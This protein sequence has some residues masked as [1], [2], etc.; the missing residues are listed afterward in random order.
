[1]HLIK[2]ARRDGNG[3]GM[4]TEQKLLKLPL[5]FDWVEFKGEIVFAGVNYYETERVGRPMIDIFYCA[6]EALN[7]NVLKTVQWDK[8]KFLPTKKDMENWD[9]LRAVLQQMRDLAA[10]QMQHKHWI[11]EN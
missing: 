2:T 5:A 9:R 8:S 3:E 10:V 7:N 6:T 11:N 1:L 4:T